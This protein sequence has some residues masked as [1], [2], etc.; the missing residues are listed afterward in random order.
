[1]REVIKAYYAKPGHFFDPGIEADL[2]ED[3]GDY[4]GMF[5][6]IRDGKLQYAVC[7]FTEFRVRVIQSARSVD[8]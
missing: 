3:Y 4:S 5:F 8:G 1:M 2:I 6:G 7:K